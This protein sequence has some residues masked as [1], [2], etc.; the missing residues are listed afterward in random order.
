MATPSP[1][2]TTNPV[3]MNA[4]NAPTAAPNAPPANAVTN[5][6]RSSSIPIPNTGT[7]RSAPNICHSSRAQSR[8]RST[9]SSHRSY[10]R[11]ASARSISGSNVSSICQLDRS[12]SRSSQ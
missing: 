1:R 10:I 6:N 5:N 11:S 12:E 3:K 9:A 2:K 7:W 8:E 4:G